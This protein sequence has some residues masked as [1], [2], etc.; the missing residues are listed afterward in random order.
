MIIKVLLFVFLLSILLNVFKTE[1]FKEYNN[2]IYDIHDKFNS[3]YKN[4]ISKEKKQFS[5]YTEIIDEEINNYNKDF[6]KH[7]SK[8]YKLNF[9]NT[10]IDNQKT[11]M[12]P[13]T[14]KGG[15]FS[16]ERNECVH[17]SDPMFKPT[18]DCSDKLKCKS[19]L[20]VSGNNVLKNNKETCVYECI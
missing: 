9:D 4:K 12:I 20:V 18:L 15:S 3:Y 14:Y 2:L 1:H 16:I 19:G 17:P 5:N 8:F 10:F 11:Y 6:C 13:D 7:Y